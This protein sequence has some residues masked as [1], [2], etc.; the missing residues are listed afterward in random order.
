MEDKKMPFA[1][2]VLKYI[3]NVLEQNK[4]ICYDEFHVLVKCVLDNC[5][6]CPLSDKCYSTRYCHNILREYVERAE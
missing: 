3:E 4:D 1:V 6:A 5:D 2:F